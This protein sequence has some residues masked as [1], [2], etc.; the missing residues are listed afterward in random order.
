[1]IEAKALADKL[2]QLYNLDPDGT[3]NLVKSR[4]EFNS[5]LGDADIP[6]MCSK[7]SDG[8]LT[9]GIVGFI[10]ALVNPGSGFVAAVF[11]DGALS[12]FTVTGCENCE[13]YQFE[14]YAL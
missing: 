5:K 11:D 14:S 12:G 8:V 1:M 7:S 13:P 6:F 10:N 4:V 2:N 9:M 3:S